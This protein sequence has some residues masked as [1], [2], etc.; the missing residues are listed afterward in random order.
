M[1][2]PILSAYTGERKAVSIV[3]T[4]IASRRETA[5]Q[6]AIILIDFNGICIFLRPYVKPTLKLSRLTAKANRTSEM[7]GIM[8]SSSLTITKI[9]Y[10]RS[11]FDVFYPK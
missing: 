7:Y 10:G 6:H 2:P 5:E 1:A 3:P 11:P 9:V 4:N 8:K